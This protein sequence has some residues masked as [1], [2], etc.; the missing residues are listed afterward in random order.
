M[1]AQYDALMAP[2]LSFRWRRQAHLQSHRRV[3]RHLQ[4]HLR[5]PLP[6]PSQLIPCPSYMPP[7]PRYLAWA[8]AVPY[9]YIQ[10]T[11]ADHCGNAVI[12]N[13]L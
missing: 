9:L 4:L 10:P 7:A 6:H 2:E 8:A 3:G 13:M 11:S 1:L 5:Q 12:K